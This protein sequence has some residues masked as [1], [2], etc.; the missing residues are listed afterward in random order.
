MKSRCVRFQ[1]SQ[2][3]LPAGASFMR[4]PQRRPGDQGQISKIKKCFFRIGHQI[5]SLAGASGFVPPH[6]VSGQ[7][8]EL[9]GAE[10][11]VELLAA[12]RRDAVDQMGNFFDDAGVGQNTVQRE[13]SRPRGTQRRHR[14]IRMDDRGHLIGPQR[15]LQLDQ[16]MASGQAVQRMRQRRRRNLDEIQ[17]ITRRENTKFI[18]RQKLNELPR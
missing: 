4:E 13:V 9:K 7:M 1:L 2:I 14:F 10:T 12:G 5:G 16:E 15:S 6:Q 17:K 11:C 18:L 3:K 8:M